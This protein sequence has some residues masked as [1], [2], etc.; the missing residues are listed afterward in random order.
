M[1]IPIGF[2]VVG[3]RI[4]VMRTMMRRYA[5]GNSTSTNPGK[6]TD[7]YLSPEGLG[8]IRSWDLTQIPDA[9]RTQ[10]FLAGTNEVSSLSKI[11]DVTLHDLDELGVGQEFQL[12]FTNTLGGSNPSDKQEIVVGLERTHNGLGCISNIE[13]LANGRAI[14]PQ[15]DRLA[16]FLGVCKF[17]YQCRDYMRPVLSKYIVWAI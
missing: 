11:G 5:G 4:S 9:I 7:L 17:F 15:R 1:P 2:S 13:E 10:I 14:T 3:M 8:D 12:Y 16:S 6:L